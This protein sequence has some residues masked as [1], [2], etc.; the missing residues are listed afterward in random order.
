MRVHS[1]PLF[2]RVK[3]HW[4]CG[5][6]L[7]VGCAQEKSSSPLRD[8]ISPVYNGPAELSYCSQ[9]RSFTS[10]VT[11][12]GHATYQARTIDG[13]GRLQAPSAAKPIRH[14]EVRVTNAAGTEVQ[15]GTTDVNGQINVTLPPN[16]GLYKIAINSRADNS[17]VKV[18]VLNQPEKNEVYSLSTTVDSATSSDFGT[19]NAAATGDILGGAFHIYDQ[20]FEA[21]EFLR[22]QIQA[23]SLFTCPTFTVADKATV[24]WAK[25]YNP[26]AYYGS[27]G[28][29]S[30]YIR[31]YRRL[32]ILGGINGNTDQADTDHFDPSIILHEYGHFLED[33]YSK[34]D[35]PAGGRPLNRPIDPRLA[36]GEGW[37]NFFQAAVQNSPYYIDTI[38]NVDGTARNAFRIDLETR[39]ASCALTPSGMEVPG[40]DIERNAGEGNYREFSVTRF[41]W[42]VFDSNDDGETIEDGFPEIWRTLNST[43]GM[44][45][46]SGAYR[47]MGFFHEMQNTAFPGDSTDWSSLRT[48]HLHQGDRS[49]YATYVKRQ[50]GQCTPFAMNPV[51]TSTTYDL[52]VGD[53]VPPINLHRN[54][55]F[56]HY[57]HPGG[58]FNLQMIY[59]T[60]SG[61]VSDLDLFVY[62]SPANF[63]HSNAIVGYSWTTPS[64][65]INTPQTETVAISSLPAGD[66]LINAMLWNEFSIGGPNEIEFRI[67]GTGDYLCP[68]SF[69]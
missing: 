42:D 50:S 64:G 25:G 35:S 66:Y 34:T 11:I 10:P 45:H 44:R 36:F 41:F 23:C 4:V 63:W 43:S 57:K 31:T 47:A 46:P 54:N 61:T 29:L 58:A 20:I 3:I 38:G 18:S 24:Y 33:V 40:C 49:E 55:L 12:T 32:F 52:V 19:L 69:P 28:G 16:T 51:N 1:F 5:F 21:N 7:L 9:V 6:V 14:A 62:K 59:K 37:G 53:D 65:G 15:C 48:Q 56:L 22:A 26:N 39:P 8:R 67:T 2:N 68:A 27:S 60:T 30:F 13:L 17:F